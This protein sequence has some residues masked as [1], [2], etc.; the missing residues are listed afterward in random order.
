[1]VAGHYNSSTEAGLLPR[2][3]ALAPPAFNMTELRRGHVMSSHENLKVRKSGQSWLIFVL[4]LPAGWELW[5]SLLCISTTPEVPSIHPSS[6]MTRER[7]KPRRG[8]AWY[9]HKA[10]RQRRQNFER[11]LSTA[12]SILRQRARADR[13]ALHATIAEPATER[14]A[15]TP[16]IEPE[17]QA[18]SCLKGV[19]E[20]EFPI[21]YV[22]E[23]PCPEDIATTPE[24]Q[25]TEPETQAGS[26]LKGE[27]AEEFPIC[28]VEEIPCPDD[29]AT[30]LEPQA[31]ET[32]RG[33]LC[34][35]IP[36]CHAEKVTNDDEVL[37][38]RLAQNSFAQNI[39]LSCSNSEAT[40]QTRSTEPSSW[41][42]AW[43]CSLMLTPTLQ[44]SENVQRVH[45]RLSFRPNP[46]VRRTRATGHRVFEFF[47]SSL[48]LHHVVVQC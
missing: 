15:H 11:A 22:E 46:R 5:C 21:F 23:I 36:T 40:W 8:S 14:S 28:Y 32:K 25:A 26:G 33:R 42:S 31:T 2:T 27:P 39:W 10:Q 16:A 37:E 9:T 38:Q 17:L 41:D 6:A 29:S 43:T 20:E 45:S 3:N 24:P 12:T 30:T 4:D 44:Q 1:M 48:V 19:S 13:M 35:D 7:G 47:F 34:E 18:G